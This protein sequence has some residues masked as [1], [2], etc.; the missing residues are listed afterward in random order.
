MKPHFQI[1]VDSYLGAS[2]AVGFMVPIVIASLAG[3]YILGTYAVDRLGRTV[4]G[5]HVRHLFTRLAPSKF[6]PEDS[7]DERLIVETVRKALASG[8]LKDFS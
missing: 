4:L 7:S 6:F 8:K 5:T 2:L 3:G 1:A